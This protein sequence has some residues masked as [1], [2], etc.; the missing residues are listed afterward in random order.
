M[1]EFLVWL[2]ENLAVVLSIPGIGT[3]LLFIARWFVTKELPRWKTALLN[4]FAR[5]IS[6]MFGI[7]YEDGQDLVEALPFVT[8]F[9]TNSTNVQQSIADE[10]AL[11]LLEMKQKLGSPLYTELEKIPI[12][13]MYDYFYN[14]YKSQLPAEIVEALNAIEI[15]E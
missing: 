2:E 7:Q 14:K 9:N 6:N 3:V 11:K 8:E 4:L 1:N 12:Q 5:L 10:I 13:A 15:K